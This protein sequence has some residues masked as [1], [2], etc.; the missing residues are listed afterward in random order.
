MLLTAKT[1]RHEAV[2]HDKVSVGS[3]IMIHDKDS[4]NVRRK[5]QASDTHDD[6]ARADDETNLCQP[7]QC[8][9]GDG[10]GTDGDGCTR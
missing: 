9:L 7:Q 2:P 1:S 3:K 6:V 4:D 5:M 8:G 10:D